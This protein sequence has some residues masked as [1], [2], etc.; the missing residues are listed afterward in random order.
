MYIMSATGPNREK[1]E[2]LLKSMR[3]HA[4]VLQVPLCIQYDN[5][6]HYSCRAF[7]GQNKIALCD[8]DGNN[9]IEVNLRMFKTI[10]HG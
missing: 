10:L 3:L 1:F 2:V 7:S 5:L 8:E 4:F 9:V 6:Y